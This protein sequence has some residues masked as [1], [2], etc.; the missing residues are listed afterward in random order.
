MSKN[1]KQHF[2]PACYLKA[3]R[4]PDAPPLHT[5]YVWIFDK[6]GM[7]SRS[8]AP[9]NIF[10]ESDMYTIHG[11]NGERDLVLEK[12][13]CQLEYDFTKVRNSKIN[14]RRDLSSDDQFLLCA[15]A[16]AAQSRTPS[17]REHH[18]SQW[19]RPLRMMEEMTSSLAEMS[20]EE[21]QNFISRQPPSLSSSKGGMGIEDIRRLHKNPLQN[22]LPMIIETLTPLL[23]RLDMAILVTKD[24]IGFITS[25]HPCV[26]FDEDSCRRPPMYQAPALMY[27][28][29]EITLPISP[30]HC[31]FLN[32]KGIN[33]YLD[34]KEKVVDDI[35]RRVRFEADEHFVVRRNVKRNYWFDPGKEPE[36]SW[37]KLN[38][39]PSKHV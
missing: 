11:K 17:F 5:P 31:L 27:E 16:A 33:G 7:A 20:P 18:R 38:P 36:D 2:V 37:A 9:E 1:K 29:I 12:G 25:D 14:F 13:L 22:M 23:Y 21:K 39:R 35:N 10:H 19:E 30:N 26:W 34:V 3:W 8:K 32:R 15:F 28:T 4:D 6:D 24:D